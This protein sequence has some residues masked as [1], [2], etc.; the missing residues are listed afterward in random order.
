MATS[1]IIFEVT[2]SMEGGYEA[3]ALGHSIFTQGEDWPELKAMALDAVRC[4]F[5]EA[6]APRVI[7][8]HLVRED[9]IAV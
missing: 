1:E 2:E 4:H 8:L 5:D 9:A 3:R 6:D 7:R